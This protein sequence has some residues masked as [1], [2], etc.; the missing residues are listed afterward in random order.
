MESKSRTEYFDILGAWQIEFYPKA[1]PVTAITSIAHDSTGLFTGSESTLT[2]HYI[3]LNGDSIV[4]DNP[5]TIGR[6]VLEL[7]YTGGVAVHGTQSTFTLTSP[8]VFVANQF[9]WGSTSGAWGI[10]KS[11]STPTIVVENLYGVFEDGEVLNQ[12]AKE[13]ANAGDGVTGTISAIT[14][15]SLAEQFPE[16]TTAVEM[17]IRYLYRRKDNFELASTQ[18]DGQRYK[19]KAPA[20]GT[21]EGLQP[22]VR[23][24]IQHLVKVVL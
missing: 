7:V 4:L 17:Q 21:H 16:Y 1:N 15:Q 6:K 11:F 22:E 24:A 2:N 10:V 18:K 5:T 20:F 9:V 19:E 13:G 14:A 8:G 23:S 3:G 12:A